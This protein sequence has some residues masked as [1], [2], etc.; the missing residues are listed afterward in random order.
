MG[1]IR[2]NLSDCTN[3]FQNAYE[4]IFGCIQDGQIK[5]HLTIH[6]AQY[7]SVDATIESHTRL[8]SVRSDRGTIYD[9]A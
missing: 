3:F 8:A 4:L 9:S 2:D 1:R 7:E 5:P 6:A